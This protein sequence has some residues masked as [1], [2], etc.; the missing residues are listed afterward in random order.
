M[1]ATEFLHMRG[2]GESVAR[3]SIDD[4]GDVVVTDPSDGEILWWFTR[5]EA[6]EIGAILL[7]LGAVE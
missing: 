5:D 7:Q 3:I 1:I 2:D 6:T 4:A